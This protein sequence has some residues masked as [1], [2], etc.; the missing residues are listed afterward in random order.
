MANLHLKI[1][2]YGLP[3]PPEN[4]GGTSW[5]PELGCLVV[6]TSV[7]EEFQ[8][9]PDFSKLYSTTFQ[10]CVHNKWKRTRNWHHFKKIMPF[11][12]Q[13]KQKQ[14]LLENPFLER[15]PFDFAFCFHSTWR[16]FKWSQCTLSVRVDSFC[17]R[18]TK[19]VAEIYSNILSIEIWQAE[20]SVLSFPC[21]SHKKSSRL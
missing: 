4:C 8:S 1:G 16:Q 10:T 3:L 12:V 11:A 7:W 19:A 14:L 9:A 5:T 20:Y 18:C 21:R 15:N 17:I 13:P 6:L 2:K